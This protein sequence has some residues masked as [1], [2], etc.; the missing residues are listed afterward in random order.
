MS[1][2]LTLISPSFSVLKD[3]NLCCLVRYSCAFALPRYFSVKLSPLMT[4]ISGNVINHRHNKMGTMLHFAH[5][6]ER[7]DSNLT[8]RPRLAINLI[9]DFAS[10]SPPSPA[11]FFDYHLQLRWKLSIVDGRSQASRRAFSWFKKKT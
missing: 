4:T 3:N 7:F 11:N 5:A 8:P 1:G 6:P 10:R 9:R 2:K